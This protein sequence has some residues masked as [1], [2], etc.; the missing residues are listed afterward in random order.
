M[1]VHKKHCVIV[2]V[3]HNT[4]RPIYSTEKEMADK[5]VFITEEVP[6]SGTL[7]AQKALN[8]LIDHCV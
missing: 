2:I 5:I 3:G 4:K 6:Q 1:I 7:L 8:K